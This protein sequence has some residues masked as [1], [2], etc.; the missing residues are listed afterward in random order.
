MQLVAALLVAGLV[1][2]SSGGTRVR[3]EEA[4]LEAR[5]GAT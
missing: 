4:D 1:L 3:R 5:W 2:I